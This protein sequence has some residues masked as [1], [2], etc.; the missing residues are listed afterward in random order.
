MR[1]GAG[2]VL[3]ARY[4]SSRLRG[5]ALAQV[6]GRSILEQC[7]RRLVQAGVARVVL[8][9]TTQP[10][11]DALEAVALGLGVA[12]Y[13]GDRDDV[14]GRFSS[15]AHAFDLDP[16][17]RATADNPA[18]DVQSPGRVIAALRATGADYIREE[19][20]PLGAAVEG[21]TAAALHRA[22][23]LATDLYDREHVTPFIRNRRDLF[24]VREV[25]APSTLTRPELRL[26][27]DTPEDLAWVRELFLRTGSDDPS[28]ATL[29]AASA[30]AKA[31]AGRHEAPLCGNGPAEA[32]LYEVA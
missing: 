27:V 26:T 16:V 29:I 20:L 5:K 7:L 11:D 23:Q 2:I 28:L 8:A 13:R 15:A 17:I 1:T 30:F 18:V 19:G 12:V 3:Q 21:M 14:L 6:G 22:A 10:E 31:T 4:G 32:G 25:D 24:H 9:T